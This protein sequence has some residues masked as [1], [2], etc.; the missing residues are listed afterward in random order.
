MATP[1]PR[2]ITLKD[3]LSFHWSYAKP[4]RGLMATSLIL[5]PMTVLLES[6][7]APLVIA[8]L[9][10]GIQ[11]GTV[12][13]ETSGWMVGAYALIQLLSSVITQRFSLY[14]MWGVQ[15]KGSR[16]MYE[17]IYAKVI[18]YPLGFFANTFTG[19]LVSR[20]NKVTGAFMNYWNTIIFEFIPI[21]V[22][23]V[24]T[25]VAM[26]FILWPYAI[27]LSILVIAYGVAAYYGTRFMRARQ[28][29]RSE[30]YTQISSQLSDS[31]SNVTAVKID[32][33]END[34]QRR[35]RKD[36]ATMV[37][38][39]FATRRGFMQ[40]ST[41]SGSIIVT[42]QTAAIFA[43]IWSVQTGFANAA[44]VYLT[45]SY[46]FTLIYVMRN[47][48]AI[49]RSLYQI[50]GDTEEILEL[51]QTESPPKAANKAKNLV[52]SKGEIFINNI[53]FTHE[54]DPLPLFKNFT[55]HIP[56]GQK[57][58]VVG[59]SGSGKTTL[60]KLLLNFLEPDAGSITIDGQD[61]ATVKAG[62]LQKNIA[63]VPQE[64]PLFHRSIYENIAYS[65]PGATKQDVITAA[66]QAYL[67]SF[68]EKLPKGY[69]TLVGE[70]GV[71]LSGGQRQRV[72]IARALIKNAPLLVLDEATSAL[73]SE[74]EAYIQKSL[75]KLIQNRTSIVI[76]HRLSTIA[77]L[78]RI[79]VMKDGNIIED[80]SHTELLK[81][82]GVYAD[83]WSRQS[84]GFIED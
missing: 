65:K 16:Q 40:I 20:I 24:A 63:Y 54:G 18:H 55:L 45:L 8:S 13:L 77:K 15:V 30:S 74:S 59:V 5:Q 31:I 81:K 29:Q 9:L 84:G 32:A 78:D 33:K 61:I 66:K 73:D 71:K 4:H 53:T 44:I 37:K 34:E 41:I 62:S 56:G 11:N 38:T 75:L 83:L 57:V 43:S 79:I 50:T 48:T 47:I 67:H 14:A 39:E 82:A 19:S 3:I 72:A 42:I 36:L 23:F 2:R 22:S 51:I 46:T 52:I 17:D 25:I 26:S 58:G 69:R 64:P 21:V 27:A 10:L 70:R 49:L 6:Y 35:F 1:A 28:K 68:I 12:S 60:S 80:G 7:V 76:A